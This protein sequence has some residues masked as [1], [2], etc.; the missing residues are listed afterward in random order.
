MWA[1]KM[2]FFLQII[3]IETVKCLNTIK[4]RNVLVES[5]SNCLF[6]LSNSFHRKMLRHWFKD[7]VE[8]HAFGVCQQLGER[9][10]I[11][12]GE[13]RKYFIYTSFIGMGSPLILYLIFAFWFN[14]RKSLRKGRSVLYE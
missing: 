6:L 8:R 13:V 9:M 1:A 11:P 4:N 2:M 10:R 3:G 5:C 12:P 14:L 7:M